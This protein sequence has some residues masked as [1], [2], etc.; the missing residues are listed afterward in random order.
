MK[1]KKGKNLDLDDYFA[2]I[3]VNSSNTDN[4]KWNID[5]LDIQ[6]KDSKPK[7][8]MRLYES[9]P[10][11]DVTKTNDDIIYNRIINSSNLNLKESIDCLVK[12]KQHL[13]FLLKSIEQLLNDENR[14]KIIGKPIKLK[15]QSISES[16]KVNVNSTL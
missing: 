13:P 1:V 6:F 3:L 9:L 16:D 15:I 4:L 2:H 8:L 10:Q 7:S 5:S 14:L 11:L 12:L